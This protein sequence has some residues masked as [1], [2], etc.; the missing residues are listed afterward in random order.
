MFWCGGV[1]LVFC[2]GN[3]VFFSVVYAVVDGVFFWCFVLF[4][5]VWSVFWGVGF[6]VG[7]FC[8]FWWLGAGLF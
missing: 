8:L 3:L 4:L 6:L 5:G 7:V 1:A 2:G